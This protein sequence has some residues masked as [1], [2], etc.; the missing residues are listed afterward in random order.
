LTVQRAAG[1]RLAENLSS[2]LDQAKVT[3]NS[4]KP[5]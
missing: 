1:R 5:G 3:M 2:A 4:A